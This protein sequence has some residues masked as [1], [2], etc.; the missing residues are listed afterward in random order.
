MDRVEPSAM[1]LLPCGAIKPLGWLERQLRIQADGPTTQYGKRWPSVNDTCGW[2]GGPGD[3]WERAPYYLDGLTPLALQLQDSDLL[4]EMQRRIDWILASQDASGRFG[5]PDLKD[6]W[7]CAPALKAITQYAEGTDDP[8]VIPFLTRFAEYLERELPARRPTAWAVM[9][10]ADLALPLLWLQQRT[11]HEGAGRSARLLMQHGFDWSWHFRDFPFGGRHCGPY[12]MQTHV[13][14]NAMG[15]KAPLVQH[16]LTGYYEHAEAVTLGWE[17]LMRYHGAVSGVFTGDEHLAGRAPT[18]GTETCAIVESLF[19]LQMLAAHTGDPVLADQLERLAYNAL[20]AAFTPDMMGHQYDQQVNQVLCSVAPRR[21]T[22]NG[23]DSNLFGLEPNYGC[24]TANLHF[25]WPKFV[26]GLWMRRGRGIAAV[27]WAP[28]QVQT[29]L[30]DQSVTLVCHTEYPFDDRI[31]IEIRCSAPADF[32]LWLRIPEWC[33]SPVLRVNSETVPVD[34]E[35][36][37]V[38][39]AG[40]WETGDRVSLQLPMRPR[41]ERRERHTV[42]I[43]LGPLV[44]AHPIAARWSAVR[45]EDWCPDWQVE[46]TEPWAYALDIDPERLKVDI[47]RCGASGVVF[48]PDG[49]PL[50]LHIAA[51]PVANWPIEDDQAAP[52]P[53]SPVRGGV[54]GSIELIPFGAAKLRLTEMPVWSGD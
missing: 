44:F 47:E 34:P 49:A 1:E 40:L 17:Q 22:N 51:V 30:D 14:N 39:I 33:S 20:P 27:C 9:R 19:S 23:P 4:W 28:C 37:Y 36:G 10:W 32:P 25:G 38:C 8:R 21:W 24:C 54:S 50:R 48:S 43:C 16:L 42:A 6:W 26:S 13:V 12:V 7:P 45:G 31:E 52:A 3:S 15:I 35:D 5:P 11:G 18:Q 2:L 41:V 46:P 29:T 53:L